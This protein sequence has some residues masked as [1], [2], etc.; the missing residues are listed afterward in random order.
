M[1]EIKIQGETINQRPEKTQ[2]DGTEALLLQ[3]TEGTK[4]VKA[5]TL[6]TFVQPE[7][8][9]YATKNEVN[10]KV[11]TETY[12]SDKAT[13]ATKTEL[14]TKLDISTYNSDKESFATK[15]MLDNT[16]Q[17]VKET[18]EVVI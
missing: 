7:L 5:S 9:G 2:L 18:D 6:K 8:S 10:E 11:S 12:N 14:G 1:A 4:H 15:E 3:D 16:T 13:F 17:I